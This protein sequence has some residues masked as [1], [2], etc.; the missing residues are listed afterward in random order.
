MKQKFTKPDFEEGTL[1]FRTDGDEVSIYGNSE[2]L[3][4]MAQ[5]CLA[6]VDADK[7]SHIHLDDYEVLTRKSKSAALILVK[8]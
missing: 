4:W 1:E 7:N 8:E 3:R 5:K 2:G 6:L